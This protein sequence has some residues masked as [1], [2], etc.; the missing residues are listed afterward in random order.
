MPDPYW[1]EGMT[2]NR[3][4]DYNTKSYL[5]FYYIIKDNETFPLTLT[6]TAAYNAR[7]GSHFYCHDNGTPQRR[8]LFTLQEWA[9]VLQ[10]AV[11]DKGTFTGNFI[12]A[13]KGT[14]WSLHLV[15]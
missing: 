11:V 9:N 15:V 4:Y 14:T 13:K 8:Y 7:G 12:Y 1:K 6:F 5:D 10:N 3:E 2:E